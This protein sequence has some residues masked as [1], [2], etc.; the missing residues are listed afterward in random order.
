DGMNGILSFQ[1]GLALANR[2]LI[3]NYAEQNKIPAI[4]N[5][6]L[7]AEAGGLMSWAPDLL[8]QFREAAHYV[9]KILKGANP[10]DLPVKHPEKYY[11]TLNGSAAKKLGINFPANILAQ[12][13]RVLS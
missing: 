13:T 4:Y 7:Y 10:G 6:T 8:L 3:V 9:S 11:L 2:T 12:A 1:G 5:A